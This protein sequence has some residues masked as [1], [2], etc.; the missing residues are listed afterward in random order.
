[1]S[2]SELGEWWLDELASDPA[3]EE[4]ITPLLLDVMVVVPGERYLDLGAGEG[5]V[6]SEV[7][8]LGGEV[9]A[10]DVNGALLG[11]TH[12]PS[13]IGL[14]PVLPFTDDSFDGAYA[15]LVLEHL[16]EIDELIH[17]V[18]RVVRVGG[19]LAVVMNH[20]VWT[21][22][23]STPIE[24]DYGEVLWRP[25]EYF[26]P[27]QTA[28]PAGER[29]VV[30]HHRPLADLLE[31]A[32]AGGWSLERFVERPHHDQAADPGMSRLL[33]CRWRLLR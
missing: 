12:L 13:V 11:L 30:F 15:T 9:V 18:A 14:L 10:L 4:V 33:A 16:S 29:E 6:A 2:W 8:R 24:D 25:G 5:R 27:G 26:A 21:A 20:P 31:P 17:E 7:S 22:P 28:V 3:Y 1:M 19:T 32:A 23:G